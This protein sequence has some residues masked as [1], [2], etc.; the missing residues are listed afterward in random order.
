MSLEGD[1]CQQTWFPVSFGG[2]SCRRVGDIALPSFLASKKSVV[3]LVETFHSK[4]NIAD[5][6]ELAEALES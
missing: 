3:D 6:N 1:V 2:L 4:N 5:T